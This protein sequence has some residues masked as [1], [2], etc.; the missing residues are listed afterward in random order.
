MEIN[1]PVIFHV[2]K[3][4]EAN[5]QL[6]VPECLRRLKIN[7]KEAQEDQDDHQNQ[8]LHITEVDTHGNRLNQNAEELEE[9]LP[10]SKVLLRIEKLKDLWVALDM[11]IWE[12]LI[13]NATTTGDGLTDLESVINTGQEDSHK[14]MESTVHNTG[15]TVNG[16]IS[17]VTLEE[18]G[19]YARRE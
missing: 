4:A 15:E 13:K 18:M 11:F 9:T 19:T 12:L 16:M 10:V 7:V 6:R 5:V 14:E 1:R 17:L 2:F 8:G 3:D